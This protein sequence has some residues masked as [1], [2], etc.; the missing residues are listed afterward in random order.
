MGEFEPLLS[1]PP[2]VNDELKHVLQISLPLVLL[3]VLEY[4]PIA[5]IN[6]FIGHLPLDASES[7]VVLSAGG[8]S[9]LFFTTVVYS[10]VIGVGTAMDALCAQAYGKGRA[11]ENGI[12]LQ[13]AVLCAGV[14]CVPLVFILFFSGSILHALGQTPEIASATQI[15]LRWMVLQVPLLFA[16]EFFK[17]VLQ[18]QTIVW[19]IVGAVAAGFVAAVTLAY[20]F[21]FHTAV[22]FAGGVLGMVF[23][24]GV[25]AGVMYP[26]TGTR[27]MHFDWS[28]ALTRLPEFLCL[29]T[30]GWIMFLSEFAGIASTSF[31]AGSLPHASTALSANTIYMGFRSILGMVYLGIGFAASVRVGNALGGNLPLRAKT[32]AWQTVG[33][34]SAWAIFTTLV[35]VTCGPHYATLYTSDPTV[36]SEATLLFYTTG[37]FQ[38]MLGVWAA[39]QGVFR[40]S[41]RPHQGAVANV[42]AFCLVGVPVGYLWLSRAYGIVGLWGGI[43]VSFTICAAYGLVWLWNADWDAMAESVASSD[44]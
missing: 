32:A 23:Y 31:L 40:G 16:Y 38:L 4:L 44:A 26:L 3:Q 43:S 13:T 36:L 21:M 42:I 17:R 30:N 37:P 12:Y 35:M 8:L 20:V 28:L 25:G 19:P 33:I 27:K 6:M 10:L 1:P 14:L 15:L 29:S 9:M 39:V 22:G 34:S 24:Y 18:G 41:G 5:I 7:R 11:G 2:L